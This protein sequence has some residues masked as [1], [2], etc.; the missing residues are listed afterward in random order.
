MY[1]SF[2]PKCI[3]VLNSMYQ[4]RS[5]VND[6]AGAKTQLA[7]FFTGLVVLFTI[8]VLLPLFF[9]LPQAVCSSII[10]VAAMKLIE[11]H[12]VEFILKL[13]AWNDLGL[14]LLTF[15]TTMLVSIEA[16]TLI[17]VGTSL[18]LVIKHTTTV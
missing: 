12:D 14:L 8:F 3:L 16:G 17:S 1:A 13:R 6:S 4:G 9:Y 2:L 7:G 11:L 10:V 5:A 18:I 15:C